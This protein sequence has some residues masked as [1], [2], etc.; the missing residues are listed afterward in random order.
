MAD[1]GLSQ[2]YW[3]KCRYQMCSA[4][5]ISSCPAFTEDTTHYNWLYGRGLEANPRSAKDLTR[6]VILSQ[7]M[8]FL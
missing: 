2:I 4:C 6:V 5:Q 8:I 1:I 3:C 7:T